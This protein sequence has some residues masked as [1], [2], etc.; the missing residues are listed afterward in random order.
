MRYKAVVF[1]FFGTLTI[2]SSPERR[3]ASLAEVAGAI[4]VP[5]GEFR[6]AWWE[7]WPE[8]CVGAMG[9]FPAALAEIARRLGHTPTAEQIAKATELRRASERTFRVMRPDAVDTIATLREWGLGT[10]L[11]SDCTD[12]LPDEWETVPVAPYI[13]V[14][15]FSYTARLRKPDPRIYALAFE[16]LGVQPSDCLYVGDGG[17]HELPG[18]KAAG[19]TAVR[20]LD[21]DGV[22]HHRFEPVEW[23]GDEIESLADILPLVR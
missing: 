17:S 2:A 12:E 8:R 3:A 19:M 15:I 20:V 4:G 9:D 22:A 16:G 1:D 7:V 13:Q 6:P 14:P 23:D 11:I 10:A 5:V 21:N 18:A